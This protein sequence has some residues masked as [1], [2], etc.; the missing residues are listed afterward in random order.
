MFWEGFLNGGHISLAFIQISHRLSN[1]Q[2]RWFSERIYVTWLS[3]RS[4]IKWNLVTFK[5]VLLYYVMLLNNIL[6]NEP[7]KII[8]FKF[9]TENI[10]EECTNWLVLPFIVLTSPLVVL[11]FTFCRCLMLTIRDCFACFCGESMFYIHCNMKQLHV[12]IF[13]YK[14]CEYKIHQGPHQLVQARPDSD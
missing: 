6:T 7:R 14:I 11:L 1:T 9:K 12:S 10:C 5:E 8:C 4:Q 13:Q 2:I 3:N